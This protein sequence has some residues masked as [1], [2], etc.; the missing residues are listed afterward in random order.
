MGVPSRCGRANAA[1]NTRAERI[2]D[3]GAIVQEIQADPSGAQTEASGVARDAAD[4]IEQSK[5]Y[6]RS[7]QNDLWGEPR[8]GHRPSRS[9]G[10]GYVTIRF[11]LALMC[12]LIKD[13]T[14]PLIKDRMEK[15]LRNIGAMKQHSVKAYRPYGEY[16]IREPIKDL[17]LE[18]VGPNGE[19]RIQQ[20]STGDLA[21][22][23]K[24]SCRYH[25]NDY[26]LSH[27]ETVDVSAA[28]QA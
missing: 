15:W 27:R 20:A 2:S 24:V 13:R 18:R 19:C 1:A 22:I 11:L 16:S 7:G 10:G 23:E 26:A 4:M 17:P 5:L 12:L 8:S 3:L 14:G 6:S 25:A 28:R 9:M 21:P